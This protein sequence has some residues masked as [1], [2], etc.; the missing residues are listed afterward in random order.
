MTRVFWSRLMPVI[1]VALLACCGDKT[2][3]SLSADAAVSSCMLCHNGSKVSDYAGPGIQNPH[4]FP[5]ADNLDCTGCH[6]G[7]PFGADKGASHVPPP[8]QIGDRDFQDD[9]A[10]AYFNRLTLTGI[11]KYPDYEVDGLTYSAMDYLQFVNPGDLRVV[12]SG[13]SCGI[14][15][16]RHVETVTASPLATET[17]I[18]S[19][20]MY[21][22][23]IDNAIEQYTGL[24]QNTAVDFGFRA[25]TDTN[26]DP[27]VD[28]SVPALR[29]FPVFSGRNDDS[30]LAI[31]N[32][33][34]YDVDNLENSID[35]VT[36]RLIKDSPLANL[37][38][39]QVA[40]TCGDCHLGSAGA[41]N[42][43]G[44]Y[45]GSG[46]T[47]CHMEYSINGRSYSRDPNV[48]KFEP[49]DPDN[50]DDPERPHLKA[51]RIISTYKTLSNGVQQQGI[52][53]YACAGCHQGSNRT[54]MQYWGI[55]LD[56]NED[57]DN[58]VQY[59][60]NPADF[61]DTGRDPR[62][63]GFEGREG[64]GN[65]TDTFN[66]REDEQYLLYEDYDDDNRDDTPEDVHYQAGM[67]CIDCHG[68]Y[69]LHGGDVAAA[70]NMRIVGR[71]EHA[72]SIS[73]ENCH[74]GTSE[75]AT[76]AGGTFNG[77]AADMAVDGNGKKLG[78]VVKEADGNYYLYSRV[79]GKKH[80]VVQTR[81][82]IV[83][84]GKTHPFSAL[85]IY[86]PKASYAMGR[87]DGNPL[88]GLGPVQSTSGVGGAHNNFAHGDTMNCA[89]CHASW[90]NTCMGCHLEGEFNGGNNFSNIT[91]E[92]IVFNE[93]NALFVYQSPVFFQL[94]VTPRGQIG[95]TTSNTKTFFKYKDQD[96]DWSRVFTFTDRNGGGN[97]PNRAA[98]P[99]LSHNAIMAHSIR[100]K[101]GPTEEGPRY[102]VACHLTDTGLAQHRPLYDTFR[103]A[104][105]ADNYE[106]LAPIFNDLVDHF[107]KNS[108]NQMNSPL[109]VHGVAGLGTGLFLFDENGCP[110][111]PVDDHDERQGCEV[112]PGSG[113]FIV[114][115]EQPFLNSRVKYNLDKTVDLTGRAT[116]GSNHAIMLEAG[117][118]GPILRD[119]AD[120]PQMAGPLGM[121][122]VQKLTDPD[123]GI[124]LDTYIDADGVV[125]G[126][127]KDDV[128]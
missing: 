122:L 84:N 38:H 40:F 55:R 87:D 80:Y 11:D 102:C 19:G 70:D 94:G 53:D 83:N 73:C 110:V 78:H 25:V 68:S 116:G 59:P 90:T 123:V 16:Q 126:V 119:G 100:G 64:D 51:H 37:W 35:P 49:E 91:G 117:A 63:F 118:M 65:G 114:P 99:S 57:V 96:D 95:Q 69:D 32:N 125:H 4:P 13:R 81:D 1:S 77:A 45:R 21:T 14:C 71:M 33:D 115:S 74:G 26:F 3:R 92:R 28:G 58:E 76:T 47:A 22:A 12:S 2:G 34:D 120:N 93:E 17:G 97:N 66:G 105:A 127:K 30:P 56:Q 124:I 9:N 85:P 86:S 75:Y 108:G 79:T 113:N 24:Y 39:E 111:N 18:L 121:S 82:T 23:G 67:G 128:K 48:N 20:A 42:R 46:C 89:S 109:W 61:R 41:N 10:E 43:T 112:P 44:D 103:A 50:I 98:H 72:V 29:E 15:H 104:M 36:G 5:G 31:R 106:A 27:N 52:T 54:V 7:N 8:P 60:A 88:T 6:G 101:V 62:L 107:G